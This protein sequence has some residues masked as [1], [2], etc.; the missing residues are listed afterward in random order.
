V[1]SRLVRNRRREQ[2]IARAAARIDS[3]APEPASTKNGSPVPPSPFAAQEE[4]A[5]V[6]WNTEGPLPAEDEARI[7][8]ARARVLAFAK[9]QALLDWLD[10]PEDCRCGCPTCLRGAHLLCS[11]CKALPLSMINE[12]T[13]ESAWD[14]AERLLVERG[15]DVEA[16][17]SRAARNTELA[18][19]S[20]GQGNNTETC[21]SGAGSDG[22][23]PPSPGEISK[24]GDALEPD[25]DPDGPV[26]EPAP[27]VRVTGGAL[28]QIAELR[29]GFLESKGE[30]TRRAYEDDFR[31]V[32]VWF[33]RECIDE[34]LIDLFSRTGKQSSAA[35]RECLERM[36]EDGGL[37][38]ATCRRTLTA[39]RGVFG[40]AQE[41]GIITWRLTT[42][43]PHGAFGQTL[44]ERIVNE[45]VE[46]YLEEE[47]DAGAALVDCLKRV[48]KNKIPAWFVDFVVQRYRGELDI[49]DAYALL[50]LHGKWL[51]KR[52][53]FAHIFVG[54]RAAGNKEQELN[55]QRLKS[56]PAPFT[57][58]VSG[59]LHD[60]CDGGIRWEK[61]APFFLFCEGCSG[62]ER[63]RLLVAPDSAR[64]E[65]GT[66]SSSRTLV[67]FVEYPFLA[68]WP[69][70][71]E[72]VFLAYQKKGDDHG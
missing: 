52:L 1:A 28:D 4:S 62:C 5:L 35:V 12:T 53:A 37:S 6:A 22:E 15:V 41:G 46:N 26:Y 29:K 11:R 47:P 40:F 34:V 45:Q 14:S 10:S 16:T 13:L 51:Q 57:G 54:A 7:D 33:G 61:P 44:H 42:S 25:G 17:L 32:A 64:L 2:K 30:N 43:A 63:C 9:D 48:R 72:S 38:P 60:D 58:S 55:T 68:R 49:Y 36:E 8:A 50:E 67:H 23:M 59:S 27:L 24:G 18:A 19:D 71:H 3:A 65:V 70:G 31:R 21:P 69:Y 66:T 56:L 39:L 20:Q